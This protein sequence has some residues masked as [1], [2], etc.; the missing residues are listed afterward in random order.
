[1]R[2]RNASRAGL[3]VM[4]CSLALAGP[5]AAVPVDSADDLLP[6]DFWVFVEGSDGGFARVDARDDAPVS[7]EIEDPVVDGVPLAG[8]LIL[9]AERLRTGPATT[10]NTV[11]VATD[12]SAID[13]DLDLTARITFD[14]AVLSA[15]ASSAAVRIVG[16]ALGG[17][18]GYEGD[19]FDGSTS[20]SS[21]SV[22]LYE[23]DALGGFGSIVET[24]YVPG[25]FSS[26][27]I[28]DEVVLATNQLY[29]IVVR[30]LASIDIQTPATMSQLAYAIVD[31]YLE[32]SAPA[33]D[34]DLVVS[35]N[36]PQ[37]IPEPSSV[38]I[39]G[40]TVLAIAAR[41]RRRNSLS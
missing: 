6:A 34:L 33:A 38:A 18:Y 29:R 19:G 17:A 36:L 9:R 13:T 30:S 1:M 32:L 37:A 11:L 22:T 35:A 5:S 8:H 14:V 24:W 31:P 27:P 16:R 21:G 2:D 40:A 4:L 23:T 10:A 20:S 28:D 7:I 3:A 12:G 25:S 39:A 41:S 15:T 26:T